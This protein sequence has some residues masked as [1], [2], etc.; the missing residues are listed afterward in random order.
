MWGP[1]RALRWC[2]RA[3]VEAEALDQREARVGGRIPTVED[4]EPM[5]QR[6]ARR[7]ETCRRS[8]SRASREDTSAKRPPASTK[9]SAG[10]TGTQGRRRGR[11]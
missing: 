8:M 4:L 1:R 3:G 5:E 11:E 7:C 2:D 9:R 10:S 6:C